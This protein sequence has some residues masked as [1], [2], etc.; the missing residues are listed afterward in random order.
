[1]ALCYTCA[2][3]VD[4]CESCVITAVMVAVG[5][6][7]C[8][9]GEIVGLGECLPCGANCE[10]CVSAVSCITCREKYFLEAGQ[11]YPC[12]AWCQVCSSATVCVGCPP[13]TYLHNGQCSNSCPFFYYPET[14]LYACLPCIQNCRTCS[15]PIH[16]ETCSTLL[17]GD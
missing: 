13:K 17:L 8:R 1:M 16:C 9:A 15:D 5:T 2:G 4:H 3:T 6:C 10:I 14:Q 12:P 11:C 7:E